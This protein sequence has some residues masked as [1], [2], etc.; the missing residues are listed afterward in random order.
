MHV[1]SRCQGQRKV[2]TAVELP[3]SRRA[4]LAV[5]AHIRHVY[6]D[7]DRLLKATSFHDARSLVE[8]ATLAKLVEWRGDDENGKTVLEDV[9]REVIVISDDEDDDPDGEDDFP[10]ADRDQSVEIVSSNPGYEEVQTRPLNY[11]G[12]S[13]REPLRELSDDDAPPGFRV[14]PDV[15]RR[16]K[17]DRRGFSRYQAWDR[18]ISRYREMAAETDARKRRGWPTHYQQPLRAMGKQFREDANENSEFAGSHTMA[19]RRVHA[20]PFTGFGEKSVGSGLNKMPSPNPIVER[21]VSVK[22]ASIVVPPEAYSH[23]RILEAS[24]PILTLNEPYELP[25]QAKP[26]RKRN[27]DIPH[28]ADAPLKR[29]RASRHEKPLFKQGGTADAPVFVS[30]LSENPDSCDSQPGRYPGGSIAYHDGVWLNLRDRALPSIEKPQSPALRPERQSPDQ[31]NHLAERMS[32][33]LGF[34]AVTPSRLPRGDIPHQGGQDNSRPLAVK[35]QRVVQHEP[36]HH[37]PGLFPRYGAARLVPVTASKDGYM[38]EPPISLG[39]VPARRWPTQDGSRTSSN[40]AAPVDSV[41]RQPQRFRKSHPDSTHLD[42]GFGGP[43]GRRHIDD[44]DTYSPQYGPPRLGAHRREPTRRFESSGASYLIPD[45]DALGYPAFVPAD[46]GAYGSHHERCDLHAKGLNI[47][48]TLEPQASSVQSVVDDRLHVSDEVHRRKQLYAEDFVRPVSL[49]DSG[50]LEPVLPRPQTNR[51]EVY[52]QT[53]SELPDNIVLAPRP[54]PPGFGY[55]MVYSGHDNWVDAS[56]DTVYDGDRQ[57]THRF[58][59]QY[60]SAIRYGWQRLLF[61]GVVSR[62]D[63][64]ANIGAG[65]HTTAFLKRL[66]KGVPAT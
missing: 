47:P 7:Y 37:E 35:R 66:S 30:S 11:T 33:G 50:L 53:R 28:L 27:Q 5:V 26:P 8:E 17:I 38:G 61:Y 46:P 41:R 65:K 15:P 9:F 42:S 14:V 3:L 43:S 36:I 56:Q 25:P 21:R 59:R 20:A 32:D 22:E 4:Q 2:G 62:G 19:P 48:G 45:D 60:P 39:Y 10:T 63:V 54:E 58:E 18:A 40:L 1:L 64:R 23:P 51:R 44:T 24:E 49:P 31:V 34:R 57:P 6:T 12:P 29:M 52:A 55:R 13:L 16:N